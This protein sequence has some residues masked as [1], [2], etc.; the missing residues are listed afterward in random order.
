MNLFKQIAANQILLDEFPFFSELNIE[1]FILENPQVISNTDI[2]D[3]QIIEQQLHVKAGRKISDGRID[4]L[5]KTASYLIIIEVKKGMLEELHL[6]QLKDYIET[7]DKKSIKNADEYQTHKVIGMLVGTD[8]SNNVKVELQE[9]NEQKNIGLT[10]KRYKTK[11]SKE[12]YIMTEFYQPKTNGLVRFENWTNFEVNQKKNGIN[13]HI[14]T[15]SKKIHDDFVMELKLSE[16][17]NINYAPNTFTLNVP[18]KQRK[19][20]FAYVILRKRDIKI[21]LSNL[22]IVPEGAKPHERLDKYP[23]LH[24]IILNSLEDYNNKAKEMIHNSFEIVNNYYDE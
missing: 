12:T 20:V 4:L 15:L 5:A 22:G 13:E 14:L 23:G 2:V 18:K 1:A 17:E 8:I 19:R 11:D 7:F 21:Y 3:P 10:I 6:R 16:N 9:N 24:F